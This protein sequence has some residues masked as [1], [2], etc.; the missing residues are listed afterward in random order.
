MWTPKGYGWSPRAMARRQRADAG[1][2]RLSLDKAIKGL[3]LDAK[4]LWLDAKGLWLDAKRIWLFAKRL[5]LDVKGLWLDA[6]GLMVYRVA[7]NFNCT[8]YYSKSSQSSISK[9]NF[10]DIASLTNRHNLWRFAIPLWRTPIKDSV[11]GMEFP[12]ET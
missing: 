5:W 12:P 8:T 10:D 9:D 4:G 1:R 11:A 6:K 2:Q 7:F 3:M